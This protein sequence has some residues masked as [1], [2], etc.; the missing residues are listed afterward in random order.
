MSR[1][2]P[3][4]PRP[5]NTKPQQQRRKKDPT[6]VPLYKRQQFWTAIL[7]A[8]AGIGAVSMMYTALFENGPLGQPPSLTSVRPPVATSSHQ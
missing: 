8:F 2:R 7:T 6:H 4:A 1:P 5:K 3:A